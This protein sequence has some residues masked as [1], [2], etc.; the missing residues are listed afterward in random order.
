MTLPHQIHEDIV[1]LQGQELIRIRNE[2]ES[3]E[4]S[5]ETHVVFEYC[6][7]TLRLARHSS[8]LCKKRTRHCVRG[9]ATAL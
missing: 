1:I 6:T 3:S 9:E 4:V 2:L 8:R 5:V 7:D